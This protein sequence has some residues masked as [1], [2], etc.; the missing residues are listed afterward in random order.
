[1][2]YSIVIP[3]YNNCEKY[4]KPCVDSIIKHTNMDDVELII[5][6]NGCTDNTRQYLRY[7]YTAIP[8]LKWQWSD[9]PLGFAGAINAGLKYTTTDKIVL[10]NN[11]TVIL[12]NDWLKR[13]DQGDLSAVLTLHSNITN[14]RFGVFFCVMIQRNTLESV[15]LLDEWFEV[16]GCEDIDY[17]YRAQEHGFE[18]TDVG[19]RGDFPIYH[20]AEGTVNDLPNWKNAF[21]QN[22]LKLAKKYNMEHYRFMLSN[23]YERAV[24][25]KGDPVFPRERQRY[26]WAAK[27]LLGDNVLEIGCSTGYGRQFFPD[28][29]NYIGM[30]YD[31]NII[32]TAKEQKW[33]GWYNMFV[34]CDINKASLA[35]N[36]TIIALSL[37]HI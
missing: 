8:N 35:A 24:F 30:D 17:C 27:N 34:A 16:G 19:H 25:L 22:E 1:M 14:R 10:L 13:L 5:S 28:N 21:Y 15:G 29:I 6:A 20:A 12:G 23:N 31:P 11:D 37:I 26:E 36:D 3:T 32:K 2:K 4:L 9:K 33:D 7:L 18:I